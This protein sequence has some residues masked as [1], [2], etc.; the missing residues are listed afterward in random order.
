MPRTILIADDSDGVRRIFGKL[1]RSRGFEVV[2]T[3]NGDDLVELAK[4][5]RVDVILTDL[6]MPGRD[7]SENMA[8]LKSDPE[9]CHIPVLIIT[10]SDDPQEIDEAISAGGLD[11]ILKPPN[12]RLLVNRVQAYLALSQRRHSEAERASEH[13]A[14]IR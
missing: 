13:S 2:E 4:L 1:L 3:D 5:H 14:A 11:V 9:L 8:E 10:G 6:D 12:F 7:Y